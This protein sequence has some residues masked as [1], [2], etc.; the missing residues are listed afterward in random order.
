MRQIAALEGVDADGY[1]LAD[2][3]RADLATG[4][5]EVRFVR[6]AAWQPSERLRARLEAEGERWT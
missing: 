2:V 1:R 5:D 6:D 4:P 3:F